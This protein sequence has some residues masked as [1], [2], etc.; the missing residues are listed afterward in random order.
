MS[1][2]T[3]VGFDD[4]FEHLFN[5][6]CDFVEAAEGCNAKMYKPPKMMQA[7]AAHALPGDGRAKAQR[8]FLMI[9]PRKS[10]MVLLRRKAYRAGKP[11]GQWCIPVESG[12]ADWEGLK[13]KL[14]EWSFDPK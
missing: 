6:I 8:V 9:E 12:F 3:E 2:F 4:S 10:G 13:S 11:K 7:R 5:S 14:K 1:L